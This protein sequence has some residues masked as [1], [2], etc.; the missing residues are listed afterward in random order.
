MLHELRAVKLSAQESPLSCM[1]TGCK[2]E[3]QNTLFIY[4]CKVHTALH[5]PWIFNFKLNFSIL[6]CFALSAPI[7]INDFFPDLGRFFNILEEPSFPSL[8]YSIRI[9][10]NNSLRPHYSLH[11]ATHFLGLLNDSSLIQQFFMLLFISE[12]FHAF[13][14]VLNG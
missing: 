4:I 12:N 3:Y 8:T 1:Q 5:K 9:D 6:R 11:S 7:I 2:E 14:I 10:S 13:P